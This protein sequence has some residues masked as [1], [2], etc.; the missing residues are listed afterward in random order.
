LLDFIDDAFA[1]VYDTIESRTS[2][3]DE[4]V[5]RIYRRCDY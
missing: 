4:R 2:Y 3:L 1:D 5:D